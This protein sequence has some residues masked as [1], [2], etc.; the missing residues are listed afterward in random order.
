MCGLVAAIAKRSNGFFMKDIDIFQEMLFADTLRGDDSTG[1]FAVN[2]DGNVGIHKQV[3]TAE[4]F[5]STPEWRATRSK[6]FSQGQMI[7]GHNRKATRGEVTDENAHPFWVEDKLVL[8]HNGSYYGS[9]KQLADVPVDSNA[10]AIHL[11][12]NIDNYEEALQ[13]VNAAYAM[14]F[15]D[16]H[17]KKLN[18]IRNK[19]R[20]LW[21]LET[22]TTYFFASEPGLLYWIVTRNDEKPI[23]KVRSLEEYNLMQLEIESSG[24]KLSEKKLDCSFR[25][26]QTFTSAAGW[27]DLDDAYMATIGYPPVKCAGTDCEPEVKTQKEEKKPTVPLLTNEVKDNTKIYSDYV[28]TE[29]HNHVS[30]A[31]WSQ[32]REGVFKTG[33]RIHVVVDDWLHHTDSNDVTLTGSTLDIYGIPISFNMTEAQ[34]EPIL[35][36]LSDDGTMLFEIEVDHTVWKKHGNDNSAELNNM[37]GVMFI[38]GKNAILCRTHEAG[39]A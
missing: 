22:N 16:V 24:V 27:E 37:Q 8:V 18:I 30:F 12:N 34:L 32:L 5:L 17:G 10:I 11:A 28:P 26:Y 19:E 36:S 29:A 15:Y 35:D 2:S 3:G 39:H 31:T 38:G 6:L 13:R 20:P 25:G 33:R 21:M 14:F 9:H 4:T 7:V 23:D 1:I